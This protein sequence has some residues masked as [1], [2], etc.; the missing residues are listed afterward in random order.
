MRKIA[1]NV[2]IAIL[3]TACAGRTPQPVAIAKVTD[4]NLTCLQASDEIAMNK[5]TISGLREVEEDIKAHDIL[6]GAAAGF[7]S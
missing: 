5:S 6:N 3:M 2:G 4:H 7:V 1:L